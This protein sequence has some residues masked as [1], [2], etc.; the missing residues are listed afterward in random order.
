[1]RWLVGF[2]FVLTLAVL[3]LSASAQDAEEGTTAE[4]GPQEPPLPSEPAGEEG[5]PSLEH[6]DPGSTPTLD[7]SIVEETPQAQTAA[8]GL[9]ATAAVLAFGGV[10]FGISFIDGCRIFP[11]E[12]CPEPSWNRPVRVTGVVLMAGGSAGMIV[13]GILLGVRKRQG[14]R[15]QEAHYGT[16]RRVQWDLARSRLVF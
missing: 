1:M 14:R 7:W 6:A 13:S 9:T 15:L 2:V 5:S 16:P 12:D 3:P 4:P 10:V 8:I 11:V